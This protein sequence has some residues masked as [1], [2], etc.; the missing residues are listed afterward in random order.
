[1]ADVRNLFLGGLKIRNL[2]VA[3]AVLLIA[4]LAAGRADL[5]RLLPKAY[6]KAVLIFAALIL[7]LGV[8]CTIDFTA[9]FTLFHKIFFTNDLWM[10]DPAD[11]YMIRMLPEGFFSDMVLRIGGIFAG[12][13][14]VLWIIFALWGYFSR[15]HRK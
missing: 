12:M 8:A 11:D 6:F 10:F 4:G 3:F 2:C 1:M 13:L 9:C 7:F 15:L 5:K 14:A